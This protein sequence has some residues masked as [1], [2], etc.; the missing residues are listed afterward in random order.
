MRCSWRKA[1]IPIALI[2]VIA[3]CGGGQSS[4]VGGHTDAPFVNLTG[5]LATDAQLW[6]LWHG[7]QQ[8]LC[9]HP[10]PLNPVT[11]GG[12]WVAPPDPRADG[13]QPHGIAVV[14]VPDVLLTNLPPQYHDGNHHDPTGIIQCAPSAIVPY[15]HS[16]LL[17][18][19]DVY[20]ASSLVL[21]PGATGWEFQNA[22]LMQLGYDV[23]GR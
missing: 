3:S 2:V 14:A 17:H 23:S 11:G 21:N 13:V 15:C 16:Y 10:I 8:E 12:S 6:G 1:A 22:I 7:A 9:D 20:V 18:G 5:G 4:Q 19:T